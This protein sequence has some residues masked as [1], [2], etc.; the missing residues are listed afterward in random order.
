MK[1]LVK[2][3]NVTTQ[4][5]PFYTYTNN[6]MRKTYVDQDFPIN[7]KEAD[8]TL[9]NILE[10]VYTINSQIHTVTWI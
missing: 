5:Q 3:M 10:E 4:A 8:E 7:T 1:A 6:I 2:E 9:D